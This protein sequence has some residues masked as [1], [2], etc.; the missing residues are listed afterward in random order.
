M[1]SWPDAVKDRCLRLRLV[2]RSCNLSFVE[3]LEAQSEP[4]ECRL[5]VE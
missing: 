2:Q 3:Q 4:W 5:G 1:G